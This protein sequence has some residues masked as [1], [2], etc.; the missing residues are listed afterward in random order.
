MASWLIPDPMSL[1]DGDGIQPDVSVTTKLTYQLFGAARDARGQIGPVLLSET[2]E[3]ETSQE[4]IQLANMH[5]A[6]LRDETVNWLWL[7]DHTG[8]RLWTLHRAERSSEI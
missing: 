7:I 1:D 3:A 5:E 8:H 4:A 6:H 2:I